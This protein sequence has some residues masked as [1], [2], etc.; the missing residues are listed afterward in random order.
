[1]ELDDSHV[2]KCK[3]MK[4]KMADGRHI[5]ICWKCHNSPTNGPIWTKLR[6]SNHIMPDLF[7]VMQLPW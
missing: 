3:K 2:T 7:T 5:G 1:M 6:W 4:F